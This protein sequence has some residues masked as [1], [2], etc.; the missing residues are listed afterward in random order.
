MDDFAFRLFSLIAPGVVVA[1]IIAWVVWGVSEGC[2]TYGS[3]DSDAS[4]DL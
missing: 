4:I 3:D 2:K 1:S